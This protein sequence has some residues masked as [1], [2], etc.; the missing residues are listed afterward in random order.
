MCMLIKSTAPFLS[1]NV[2]VEMFHSDYNYIYPSW[3]PGAWPVLRNC[4]F[5]F[6]AKHETENLGNGRQ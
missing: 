5:A 2:K 3:P 6:E 1:I 4:L